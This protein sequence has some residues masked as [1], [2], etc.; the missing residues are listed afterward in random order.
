MLYIEHNT[1]ENCTNRWFSCF[2]NGSCLGW[3]GKNAWHRVEYP[4]IHNLSIATSFEWNTTN[5]N[6]LKKIYFFVIFCHFSVD[7]FDFSIQ[8]L[9]PLPIF[10][11]YFLEQKE[12]EKL[13]SIFPENF[14]NEQIE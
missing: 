11:E 7:S 1:D 3:R 13:S 5:Y 8:T 10:N 12:N 9:F 6:L 2:S 4:L 14:H